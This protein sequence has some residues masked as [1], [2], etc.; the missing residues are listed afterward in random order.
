MTQ[1]ACPCLFQLCFASLTGNGR[2]FRFPC[3]AG[4]LVDLDGLSEQSR[5]DYFYARA[6][7][8]RELAQPAIE[9]PH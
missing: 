9:W 6:M 4:G 7:V 3:D 1:P 5:N 8:G 2:S